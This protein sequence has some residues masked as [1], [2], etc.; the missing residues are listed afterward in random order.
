M[1]IDTANYFQHPSFGS[2]ATRQFRFGGPVRFYWDHIARRGEFTPSDAMRRGTLLDVI[3]QCSLD[4]TPVESRVF[5]KPAEYEDGVP[6]NLKKPSHRDYMR[7]VEAGATEAGMV[8]C[9]PA[10]RE[11]T[12]RQVEIVEQYL[13]PG[14]PQVAFVDGHFKALVDVWRDVQPWTDLKTTRFHTADAFWADAL[15]LGYLWQCAQYA[16]VAGNDQCE[17]LWVSNEAPWVGGVIDITGDPLLE[18]ERGLVRQTFDEIAELMEEQDH[19][20]RDM[21]GIPTCW[22][23]EYY[24]APVSSLLLETRYAN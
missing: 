16:E 13:E 22:L 14:V 17:L 19:C 23:G 24:G 4:G 15:K 21:N 8:Y 9:T 10:E 1:N 11:A 7:E 3:V 6:I 20:E 18:K 5:V 12:K 2:H